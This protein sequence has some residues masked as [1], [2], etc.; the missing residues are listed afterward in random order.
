M[1]AAIDAGTIA[2]WKSSGVKGASHRR[3]ISPVPATPT[4]I[5]HS[6]HA[7]KAGLQPNV[8]RIVTNAVIARLR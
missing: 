2:L 6:A 7:R 4:S 8:A 3:A 1:H 5:A